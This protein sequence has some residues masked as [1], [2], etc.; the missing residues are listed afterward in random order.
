MTQ[1]DIF[2][3]INCD[4]HHVETQTGVTRMPKDNLLC[5]KLVHVRGNSHLKAIYSTFI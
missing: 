3:S 5:K 1:T 4:E 2:F